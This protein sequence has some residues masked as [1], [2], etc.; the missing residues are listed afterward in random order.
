M[1]E[2]QSF[3]EQNVANDFKKVMEQADV[4]RTT[5]V[6]GSND[7]DAAIGNASINDAYS[8]HAATSI[9]N[10]WADLASTF[11]NFL[12]NFQNWYDQSVDA[13]KANQGLQTSTN[14]VQGV[15]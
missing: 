10:Q 4:V 3:N 12:S 14:T 6:N 7:I 13:A 11:E 8:G 1:N 15:E 2:T 5:L 9:K